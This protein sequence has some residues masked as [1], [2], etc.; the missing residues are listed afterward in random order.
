M[1]LSRDKKETVVDEVARLLA[2]S[3]LTV[4][5]RYSGTPVKS[6]QEL[7]KHARESQ[8]KVRVIKNRLAKAAILNDDRLKGV[9]TGFLTGQLMYAF[10]SSDDLAPAQALAEFSKSQPQI[11]FVAGITAD[12]T[13]LLAEEVK[14]LASLPS[15]QLLR[16]Q[17]V[18]LIATPLGQFTAMLEASLQS[19][20]NVLNARARPKQLV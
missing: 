9:D 17:L 16:G 18:G 2:D 15:K 5:A 4:V 6:M 19:M 12:G 10:N 13:V 1:A 8:T 11:E 20:L 3:K 7:R 14:I